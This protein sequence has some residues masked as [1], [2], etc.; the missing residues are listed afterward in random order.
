[1]EAEAVGRDG[2]VGR[3][4]KR[5]AQRVGTNAGSHRQKGEGA[6]GV[7]WVK[8]AENGSAD[9]DCKLEAGLGSASRKLAGDC[10]AV[11]KLHN[12]EDDVVTKAG[13]PSFQL[14]D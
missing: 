2:T 10:E 11:P 14:A 6:H 9:M 5:L 3:R 4:L 1:M 7:I 13:R 8:Y 12:A